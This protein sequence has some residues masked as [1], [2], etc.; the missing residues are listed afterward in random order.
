MFYADYIASGKGLHSIENYIQTHLLPFYAN[1]HSETGFLAEHSEHFRKEA[2]Q[3]V[4]KCFNT[5]ERDSIIFVGQ[6]STVS[7]N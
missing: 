7:I 1:V 5:D 3:I 2:K 6:G 4:K